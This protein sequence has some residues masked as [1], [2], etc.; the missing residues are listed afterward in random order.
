MLTLVSREFN[1]FEASDAFDHAKPI[2][3]RSNHNTQRVQKF[4]VAQRR[5]P[6]AFTEIESRGIYVPL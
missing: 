6:Q 3:P 4:H 5:G 2:V 1:V